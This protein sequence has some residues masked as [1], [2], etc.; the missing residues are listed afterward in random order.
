MQTLM[1]HLP[2]HMAPPGL[3]ADQ[4][5]P[6]TALNHLKRRQVRWLIVERGKAAGREQLK[7]IVSARD[8]S[9]SQPL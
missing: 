6:S 2:L 1:L 3:L 4:A 7:N 9:C 8:L 5:A